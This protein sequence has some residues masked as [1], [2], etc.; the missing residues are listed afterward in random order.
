MTWATDIAVLL[1]ANFASFTFPNTPS[2][3]SDV[4]TTQQT[5]NV[6]V[7]VAPQFGWEWWDNGNAK[8]VIFFLG[9]AAGYINTTATGPAFAL[10]VQPGL[11]AQF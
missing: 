11:A 4:G 6:G 3:S 2:A 9:I 5:F 10:G 8:S 7:Y 1:D